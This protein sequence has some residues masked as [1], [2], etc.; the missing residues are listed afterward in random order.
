PGGT[1]RFQQFQV[2]SYNEIGWKRNVS[3]LL[4]VP[5][6][7]RTI[8]LDQTTLSNAGLSDLRLGLRFRLRE[9]NP[10]LILEGG[11]EAPLG[12]GHNG[13][14]ARGDG[15][16]KAWVQLNGGLHLPY[17]PGFIQ[18]SRGF[19][20]VGTDE[21]LFSQTTVDGGLWLGSSVLV[22]G[23][24]ADQVGWNSAES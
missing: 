3:L 8:R 5:F 7:D 2:R 18:A 22:G 23:R 24:Y 13:F 11:W 21:V 20:Y 16:Q 10:G 17:V 12:Y 15:R 1:G 9:D 4:D 14:P 6:I 19:L